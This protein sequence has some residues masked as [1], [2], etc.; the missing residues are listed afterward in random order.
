MNFWVGIVFFCASPQECY[1]YRP[2]QTFSSQQACFKV[3]KEFHTRIEESK[4]EFVRSTC[5]YIEAGKTV[6]GKESISKS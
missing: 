3:V 1:F 4:A 5:M 6:N 2:H